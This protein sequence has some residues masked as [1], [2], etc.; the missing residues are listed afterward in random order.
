MISASSM[1][2]EANEAFNN[3]LSRLYQKDIVD[4]DA[5]MKVFN[6]MLK[7]DGISRNDLEVIEEEE[8]E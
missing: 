3:I 1:I 8:N 6:S 4:A 7:A 5:E 2:K